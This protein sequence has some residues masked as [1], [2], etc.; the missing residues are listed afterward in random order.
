MTGWADDDD[1]PEALEDPDLRFALGVQWHPEADVESRVV[2][3]FV[4]EARRR[5]NG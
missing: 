5:R 2:A 3:A 4:E 1:L